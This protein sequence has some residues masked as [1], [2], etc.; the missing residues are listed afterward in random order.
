[1]QQQPRSTR[2]KDRTIRIDLSQVIYALKST[3]K[4]S[5]RFG[6]LIPDGVCRILNGTGRGVLR[7]CL[8][9]F[10]FLGGGSKKERKSEQQITDG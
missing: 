7:E 6:V 3:S 8:G 10:L 2:R 4:C 9:A 1:M 5:I